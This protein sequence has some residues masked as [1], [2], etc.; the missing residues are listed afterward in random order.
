MKSIT[1]SHNNFY[2]NRTNFFTHLVKNEKC[3]YHS[4]D[5][6]E[7]F[8][9]TEG[10][11][12]H[13]INGKHYILQTGDIVFLDLN[14]SH[15]FCRLN[16]YFSVRRD[17]VI[18]KCDFLRALEYVSPDL[19]ETFFIR[20]QPT[21]FHLPLNT[22]AYYEKNIN[23]IALQQQKNPKLANQLF[24]AFL[25]DLISF[26][27]KAQI[28]NTLPTASEAKTRTTNGALWINEL[29]QK[30]SDHTCFH[31]TIDDIMKSYY[32]AT[33]YMRTKFK[34]FTGYTMT[35]FDVLPLRCPIQ[36]LWENQSPL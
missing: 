27:L 14:D 19:V 26:T 32:Y 30:F 5:F 36:I 22:L 6:Y 10:T 12:D 16:E 3:P 29:I 15:M 28:S 31:E 7:V 21:S 35:E 2:T 13:Y 1:I 23:L 25:V 18:S 17:L 4:H 33:S 9:I 11:C 24:R 34:K 8:Y 20:N